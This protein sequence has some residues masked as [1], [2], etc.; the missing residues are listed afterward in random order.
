MLEL[1]LICK[2]SLIHLKLARP[3]GYN[4]FTYSA[5]YKKLLSMLTI[6]SFGRLS[7][8]YFSSKAFR[9]SPAIKRSPQKLCSQASKKDDISI[10][11]MRDVLLKIAG[12]PYSDVLEYLNSIGELSSKKGFVSKVIMAKEYAEKVMQ[13][14]D[15]Q[16]PPPPQELNDLIEL[17]STIEDRLTET[18]GTSAALSIARSCLTQFETEV[19]GNANTSTDVHLAID[20]RYS[21]IG[22]LI[23]ILYDHHMDQKKSSSS[24]PAS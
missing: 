11:D 20:E 3:F 12:Y 14:P 23:K 13:N 15:V 21:C 6:H 24:L 18:L 19:I 22:D 5:L 9:S 17:R 16:S 4:V 7:H 2:I 8:C 1:K 10:T